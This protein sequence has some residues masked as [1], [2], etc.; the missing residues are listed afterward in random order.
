MGSS[1]AC[2][3]LGKPSLPPF[4]CSF[5]SGLAPA[6]ELVLRHPTGG[7]RGFGCHY[8]GWR[9]MYRIQHVSGAS[10]ALLAGRDG[11]LPYVPTIPFCDT[12]SIRDC[13]D[14]RVCLCLERSPPIVLEEEECIKQRRG[15]RECDPSYADRGGSHHGMCRVRQQNPVESSKPGSRQNRD[16]EFLAQSKAK[17]GGRK[18]GWPCKNCGKGI[19]ERRI[20]RPGK[21][22]CWRHRRRRIS[23]FHDRESCSSNER[24]SI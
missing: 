18:E 10:P 16:R 8:G 24:H 3:F 22:S 14:A 2:F 1:P 15:S 11:G 7:Q 21:I 23:G 12:G 5:E 19:L 20:G 9:G 6:V 4:R 13:L 17:G